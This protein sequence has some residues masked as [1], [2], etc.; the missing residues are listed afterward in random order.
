MVTRQK[1]DAGRRTS[2]LLFVLFL[3]VFFLLFGNVAI[4]RDLFLLVLFV[5]IIKIFGD[6]V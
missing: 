3:F 1:E 4:F 6:Y 2:E 5:F